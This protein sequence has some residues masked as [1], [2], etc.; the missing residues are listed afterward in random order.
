[1][2][3]DLGV[4]QVMLDYTMSAVFNFAEFEAVWQDGKCGPGSACEGYSLR[5]TYQITTPKNGLDYITMDLRL[6]KPSNVN[7]P[8]TPFG[9][10]WL[11]G[12]STDDGFSR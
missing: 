11:I 7:W 6:T 5:G 10:A 2:A 4:S 1:M 9:V 3:L 8:D 12:F